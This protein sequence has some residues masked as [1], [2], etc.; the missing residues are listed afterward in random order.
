MSQSLARATN[1]NT[2]RKMSNSQGKYLCAMHY[3]NNSTASHRFVM[4][5]LTA[6]SSIYDS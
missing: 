3:K 1:A 6:Y 4:N 5:S 2:V